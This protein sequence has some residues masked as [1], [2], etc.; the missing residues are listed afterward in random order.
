MSRSAPDPAF[1]P[2]QSDHLRGPT[3]ENEADMG[4]L[5]PSTASNV[6]PNLP[7]GAH[8]DA[9]QAATAVNPAPSPSPRALPPE[10]PIYPQNTPQERHPSAPPFRPNAAPQGAPMYSMPP[11]P[12]P[13]PQIAFDPRFQ[14]RRPQKHTRGGQ[15]HTKMER[16]RRSRSPSLESDATD[17][18]RRLG[19]ERFRPR[20]ND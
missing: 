17:T 14:K 10:I 1:S 5:G 3:L 8:Q 12:P 18:Y 11:M 13:G 19:G 16:N 6:H 9:E 15:M 4:S 2:P 20:R 7:R